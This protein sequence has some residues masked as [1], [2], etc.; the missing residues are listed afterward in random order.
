M[1]AAAVAEVLDLSAKRIE[2]DGFAQHVWWDENTGAYCSRGTYTQVVLDRYE[3]TTLAGQWTGII[4]G[5]ELAMW[6]H[7]GMGVAVWNDK[8]ERT[9]DEV[10]VAF[11]KAAA[12]VRAG[13]EG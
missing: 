2:Q 6:T 12:E 3:G 1:L 11:Q 9:Q 13:F 10:V 5:C 7:L 4:D 8:P